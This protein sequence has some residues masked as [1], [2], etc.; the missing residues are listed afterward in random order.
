MFSSLTL[1]STSGKVILAV[2]GTTSLEIV[3]TFL[4]TYGGKSRKESLL[5]LLAGVPDESIESGE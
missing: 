2:A 4:G 3:D 1:F 5:R